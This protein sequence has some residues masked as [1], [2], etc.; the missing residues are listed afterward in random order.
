MKITAFCL[1]HGLKTKEDIQL[2]FENY[3]FE[4]FYSLQAEIYLKVKKYSDK[5]VKVIKDALGLLTPKQLEAIK[6]LYYSKI[7]NQTRKDVAKKLGISVAS[8][9]DRL[10][11]AF[12]KLK[13]YVYAHKG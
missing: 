7:P 12:T 10:K 5:R 3:P 6:L 4:Y 9:E 1:F 13:K 2:V 11:G 8:L